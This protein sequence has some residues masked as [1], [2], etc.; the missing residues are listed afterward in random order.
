MVER[1]R[2]DSPSPEEDA[3]WQTL[4]DLFADKME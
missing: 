1:E 4:E 3:D 2:A